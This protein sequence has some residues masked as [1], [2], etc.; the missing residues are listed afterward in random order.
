MQTGNWSTHLNT[1]ALEWLKEK[2]Q[3]AERLTSASQAEM[4]ATASRAATAAERPAAAADSQARTVRANHR[5][6]RHDYRRYRADCEHS[7]CPSLARLISLA[8]QVYAS[9]RS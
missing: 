6:C 7:W 8:S 4:A 3:E 1:I 2:D 5:Y 9:A